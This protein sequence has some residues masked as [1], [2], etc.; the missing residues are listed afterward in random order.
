MEFGENLKQARKKMNVT[1]EEV[2]REL[3]VSRQTISSWEN[4]R[5]YP[6]IRSLVA[7]SDY[8]QISLD[9]LL[10]EDDNMLE[11]YDEQGQMVDKV[12]RAA[13]LSYWVNAVFAVLTLARQFLDFHLPDF[14][15]SGALILSLINIVLF[16]V[17]RYVLKGNQMPKHFLV[18]G[19]LL[20]LLALILVMIFTD[21]NGKSA[22]NFGYGLGQ[23]FKVFCVLL[24][25]FY[26]KKPKEVKDDGVSSLGNS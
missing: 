8:Y 23:G 4:Q 16:L 15:A 10:R 12:Q 26:P 3:N 21:L 20:L 25:L 6:D 11:H 1:Q 17:L 7:L 14:I 24:V 5:S 19:F 9:L 13:V 22:Y 18:K 2:A